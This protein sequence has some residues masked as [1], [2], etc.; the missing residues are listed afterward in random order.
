MNFFEL[1][2]L[3]PNPDL[4][5]EDV[6]AA[7]QRALEH[8]RNTLAETHGPNVEPLSNPKRD[9]LDRAYQQLSSS[10]LRTQ[11]YEQLRRDGLIDDHD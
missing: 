9:L 5:D 6:N 1:L 3:D 7:Y 4:S 8:H 2:G 10:R 11:Y